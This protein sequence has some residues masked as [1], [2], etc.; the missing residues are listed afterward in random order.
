MA[1]RRR[2]RI[3]GIAEP[4]L[5]REPL[6]VRLCASFVDNLTLIL[7]IAF[8]MGAVLLVQD[9]RTLFNEVTE[10]V[11]QSTP[12]AAVS[13]DIETIDA[14]EAHEPVLSERVEHALNCTY[15]DYRNAHY[16]ECVK[17][18][19]RIYVRPQAEPDD[20]GLVIYD[21]PVIYARLDGYTNLE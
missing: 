13:V 19:S 7:R 3:R 16:D 14:T 21:A 15:E 12:A 2:R 5:V 4:V 6:L 8:V 20:T 17:E 1:K 10:P 18:P 9:L 11:A